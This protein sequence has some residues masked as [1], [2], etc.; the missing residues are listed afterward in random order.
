MRRPGVRAQAP[1]RLDAVEP[2]HADVHHDDVGPQP[3]RRLHR[4]GAVL[5]L[6]DDL[7]VGLDVEHGPEA[8]AHERVVVGD[9]DADRAHARSPSSGRLARTAKPS[10]SGPASTWPPYNRARSRMPGRPR[11]EPGGPP[12]ER[13]RALRTSM[14][15][16][17][18]R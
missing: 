2:R 11:P 17:S 18:G 14:S 13:P 16:A 9:E 1:R 15:I 4:L 5:R 6:A 10:R 8:A 7:E 12:F 3:Q